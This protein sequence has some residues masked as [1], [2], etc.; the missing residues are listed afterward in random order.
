MSLKAYLH[1]W[2][3]KW[4]EQVGSL[5]VTSSYIYCAS[6]RRH[7][8]LHMEMS[9]CSIIPRLGIILLRMNIMLSGSHQDL[10]N[11]L[12]SLTAF[13]SA[14]MYTLPHT[15]IF[16]HI[17]KRT[18]IATVNRE[19]RHHHFMCE[20]WIWVHI[21][22]FIYFI[23]SLCSYHLATKAALGAVTNSIVVVYLVVGLVGKNQ[24]G[25]MKARY[26]CYITGSR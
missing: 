4:S 6:Y 7:L 26:I 24:V 12:G 18:A 8:L 15:Q 5:N 10:S 19:V 14:N 20:R 23:S 9:T 22:Y 3:L 11:G 16:I 25:K 2:Y 21:V 17:W 13:N 1:S